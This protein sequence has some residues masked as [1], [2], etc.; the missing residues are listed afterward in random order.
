MSRVPLPNQPSQS[1]DFDYPGVATNVATLT[2][3]QELVSH[4]RREQAK[5]QDLLSSLSFSLRSFNNLNQFL[6]LIPLIVSRVTDADAAALIL[7]RPNGQVSLEQLYCHE[8]QQCRNI[9]LALESVTRQFAINGSPA[10]QPN[11]VL[12]Q[13]LGQLLGENYQWFS[14]AILVR[15]FELHERGRLYLFSSN[16]EYEW[17]E[18]RQ[19]LA[20]LVADQTAVAIE[21][22]TLTTQLRKQERITRE[23]EIG[24]EIQ[25]RLLPNYSPT[26]DGVALA[27]TCQT[28]NQVGGDY[29]DFIPIYRQL[30]TSRQYRL[31]QA[32]RW[33]LVIGDVMG[34]GVPAG[35]IMTMTRGILRADALHHHSPAEILKNLNQVMYADLENSN[36]FVTLFYSEY[37]PKT[38]QLSFSNAAHNPPLLWRAREDAIERLDTDGMLIGLDANTE[39]QED[40]VTLAPGDTIIYYTD[41]FT[42]AAGPNGDRFD[43]ENLLTVFQ[44]ACHTCHGPQEILDY[45]FERLQAFMGER[46]QSGDDVTLIVMQITPMLLTF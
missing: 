42:D 34:K 25:A 43:E 14:T 8:G 37:D 29:Y 4:L 21:N 36:R 45:L 23:L 41:G 13:Q 35:L 2:A 26:I 30:P 27:A 24:A 15:N 31:N 5:A 22:D 44:E 28:A 7:F 3:L 18:T 20:Q 12:E 9:R 16:P 38:R 33:G 10:K 17:T 40:K 19:K 6:A 1:L 46:N 11:L 39:Y 32:D